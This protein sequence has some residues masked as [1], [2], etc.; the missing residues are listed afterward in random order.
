[1]RC[2]TTT[3][4]F[5]RYLREPRTSP[6]TKTVTSW[7]PVA[8]ARRKRRTFR[9]LQQVVQLAWALM[10]GI[11]KGHTTAAM[12]TTTAPCMAAETVARLD[13]HAATMTGEGLHHPTLPDPRNGARIDDLLPLQM[14]M[15][16]PHRQHTCPVDLM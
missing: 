7:I 14:V 12:A 5:I 6:G 16:Y 1:M 4:R 15:G 13:L 11:R 10:S 8:G 2:S 9:L 3:S